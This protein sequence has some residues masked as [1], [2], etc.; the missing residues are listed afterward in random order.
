MQVKDVQNKYNGL[1]ERCFNKCIVQFRD[2]KLD[3][4]EEACIENCCD[5][6]MQ[7]E[8]R[9]QQRFAEENYNQSLEKDG[10]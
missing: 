5:K 6:F 3:T 7:H 2:K 4:T 1:A 8:A 10:K 9:V